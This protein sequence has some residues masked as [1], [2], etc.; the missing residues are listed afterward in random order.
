MPTPVKVPEKSACLLPEAA[1]STLPWLEAVPL[2]DPPTVTVP[3]TFISSLTEVPST[4]VLNSASPEKE[5]PVCCSMLI[6]P[7]PD[8]VLL[9]EGLVQPHMVIALKP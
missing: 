4:S 6:H 7:V 5:L 8:V 1:P 2:S 3:D 9:S